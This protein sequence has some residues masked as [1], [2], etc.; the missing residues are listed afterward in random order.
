[1]SLGDRACISL[2]LKTSLPAFTTEEA[3]E[4]ANLGIKLVKIR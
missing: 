2:A 3:W 4:K 1:M